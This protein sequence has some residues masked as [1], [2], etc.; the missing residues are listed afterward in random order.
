MGGG[1]LVAIDQK[2]V[3]RYDNTAT[4]VGKISWQIC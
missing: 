4:V 2:V 1:F 3:E